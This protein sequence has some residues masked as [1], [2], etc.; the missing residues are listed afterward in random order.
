MTVINRSRSASVISKPEASEER[1]NVGF[2]RRRR[3]RAVQ[4][5]RRWEMVGV[6][7]LRYL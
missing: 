7:L 6:R 1:V 5:G 2:Q 3:S 4:W